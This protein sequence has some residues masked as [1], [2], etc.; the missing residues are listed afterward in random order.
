[1]S[2][3]MYKKKEYKLVILNIV[4]LYKVTKVTKGYPENQYSSKIL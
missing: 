4:G 2:D 3:I 1:M